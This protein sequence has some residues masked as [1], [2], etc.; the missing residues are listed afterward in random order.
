M[1]AN[2]WQDE[3]AAAQPEIDQRT[4]QLVSKGRWAVPG[5]KAS[6]PHIFGAE[7]TNANTRIGEVRRPVRPISCL[8]SFAKSCPVW[9]VL[10]YL[11]N[12]AWNAIIEFDVHQSYDDNVPCECDKSSGPSYHIGDAPCE[13]KCWEIVAIDKQVQE[14]D[15]A[16]TAD[17]KA[18]A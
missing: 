3:V 17:Q 11:V 15:W 4:E 7:R 14:Y 8:F 6:L 9:V 2:E 18:D 5:Y 10:P 12:S 16:T 1:D 13:M